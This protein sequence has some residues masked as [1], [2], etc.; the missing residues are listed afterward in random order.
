MKIWS[1]PQKFLIIVSV[2]NQNLWNTIS[3]F[4]EKN[5]SYERIKVWFEDKLDELGKECL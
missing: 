5:I 1:Q 3:L 4:S 2:V